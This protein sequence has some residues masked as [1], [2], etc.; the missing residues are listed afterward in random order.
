MEIEVYNRKQANLKYT[1]I[2]TDE[3]NIDKDI[4]ACAIQLDSAFH[5]LRI[6][7]IYRS[8]SGN[9]TNFFNQLDLTCRN[10]I[11]TNII[12]LHVMM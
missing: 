2:N 12:S 3:Y 9:F 5:K 7:T 10:F 6:L 11:V 1:T 4:E 8:P